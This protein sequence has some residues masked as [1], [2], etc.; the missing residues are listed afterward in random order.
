M[1]KFTPAAPAKKAGPPAGPAPKKPA[2]HT[3]FTI[4]T[5]G[6]KSGPG[7]LGH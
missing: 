4:P 3:G 5:G 6:Q 2:K 1:K 7:Y